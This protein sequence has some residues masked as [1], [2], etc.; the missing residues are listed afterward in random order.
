MHKTPIS[1]LD[2]CKDDAE[3]IVRSPKP[4]FSEENIQLELG[5]GVTLYL[6]H[7]ET[8]TRFLDILGTS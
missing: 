8:E 4:V 1:R 6:L 5:P 2:I 3:K 7:E